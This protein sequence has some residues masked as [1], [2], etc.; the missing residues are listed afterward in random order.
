MS[1]DRYGSRMTS[2]VAYQVD[3]SRHRQILPIQ[4]QVPEV[5][6]AWVAP[7]ATLIGNVFV[8]NFA[9]VWFGATIKGDL[10]PVR[11]G[12]FSSIGD[13]CVINTMHSMHHDQTSS[14]NIGKNVVV[15][16][17]CNIHPSIIDDDCIVGAGSII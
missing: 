6:K 17:D 3:L 13:G 10:N 5:N 11:I 15:E 14:V 1:M 9:T 16:A 4:D 2:D 7:N 8:S 12:S